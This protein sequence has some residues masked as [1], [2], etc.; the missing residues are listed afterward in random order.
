[1]DNNSKNIINYSNTF[2]YTFSLRPLLKYWEKQIETN[3]VF[4]LSY[5]YI[6]EKLKN[7]PELLESITDP[8]V[9]EKNYEL[10]KELLNICMPPAIQD[11]EFYAA[12]YPDEHKSFYETRA[13][14]RLGLFENRMDSKCFNENCCL[15]PDGSI[16][17]IY[18]IILRMFYG[19]NI[20]YE[21]PIIYTLLDEKTKL[22]RHYRIRIFSWFI[23][24]KNKGN[25]KEITEEEKK[26]IFDHLD[27]P[28]VLT[29]IIPPNNFELDG[30][31]IYNA[32]DITDQETL[33]S[34]KFDLIQKESL[35]S[36]NR[37]EHLQHKLR[38]LLKKP[39]IMLGLIAFPSEKKDMKN[40]L[41]MGSSIILQ[42]SFV[43]H[44]IIR[45]CRIYEDVLKQNESSIQ[46]TTE[47]IIRKS[48]EYITK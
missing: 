39:E 29:E 16:V 13:F 4:A 31:L 8:S 30:F 7:A 32:V 17:A 26:T 44:E 27:D 21:Y 10:I 43:Q 23:E 47:E 22:E 42:D 9:I 5:D 12:V 18:A 24:L 1:M 3:K 6:S 45:E 19:L 46:F 35:I 15:T 38:I 48:L 33:S 11:Y 28:K 25:L 36:I 34:L 14:K 20:N 40:S 2:N 41:K 37:F